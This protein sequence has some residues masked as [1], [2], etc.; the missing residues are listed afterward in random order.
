MMVLQ[1][2]LSMVEV[3]VGLAITAIALLAVSQAMQSM[4]H[5]AERQRQVMLAQLCANNALV[6]VRLMGRYPEP[7]QSSSEC[8]QNE[9]TFTVTLWVSA[10][11]NPSLRRVQAQVLQNQDSVL[12]V[13]TLIGRY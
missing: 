5:A 6:G 2:G 8:V 9:Q 4:A 13:V 12:S 1:R 7:G 3:L 11:A 10:T